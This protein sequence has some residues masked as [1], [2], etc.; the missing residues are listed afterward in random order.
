MRLV[1][2]CCF[3]IILVCT[4][5]FAAEVNAADTNASASADQEPKYTLPYPG[6]LPDSPFYKLKVLR[7]TITTFLISDPLKKID[8]YLLRADKGI[9]G[10]SML[11]EKG[12]ISLAKETA[13][14]AEHNMTLAVAQIR[15]LPKKPDTGL[16]EK[17]I[18]ASRKHQSI[19]Q[20]II[21]KTNG[22]DKKT[23]KTVEDF[24]KSNME[25]LQKLFRRHPSQWQQN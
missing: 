24:S 9:A 10:A 14:K 7:D 5:F 18:L 22:E 1:L 17:L 2:R 6:M 11:V 25:T 8:F 19:L 12:N 15:A 23:F 20:A 4:I 3:A 21:K 13:L 16:F